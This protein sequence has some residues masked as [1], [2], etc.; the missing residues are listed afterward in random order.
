MSRIART[1]QAACPA[2]FWQ[3][4]CLISIQCL[5]LAFCSHAL[6]AASGLVASM[7]SLSIALAIVWMTH[8]FVTWFYRRR[9]RT[10]WAINLGMGTAAVA[11]LFNAAGDAGARKAHVLGSV[12]A[13]W[14]CC[15]ALWRHARMIPGMPPE[16]APMSAPVILAGIWGVVIVMAAVPWLALML[17]VG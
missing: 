17:S 14:A 4:I 2:T 15:F 16:Q 1:P 3:W 12:L 9:T 10:L 7:V 13:F 8:A 6:S 11:A 5:T